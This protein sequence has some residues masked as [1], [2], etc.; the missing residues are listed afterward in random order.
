MLFTFE[1]PNC[2][3]AGGDGAFAGDLNLKSFEIRI[4]GGGG[5][6]SKVK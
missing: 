1:P 3:S 4:N 2:A 5:G 6:I